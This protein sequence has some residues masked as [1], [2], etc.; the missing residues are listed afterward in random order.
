MRSFRAA[1]VFLTRI[2]VGVGR[3]GP[4]QLSR[5]VP[6]F[7]IVGAGI[8]ALVG[9]VYLALNQA[10][11]ATVSATVAVSFG[12]AITG[13]F[14][15]D[16]LADCADAFAGGTTVER[17]LEILKDSRLGTYGTSALALVLLIE[18]A[19]LAALDPNTGLRSLI[20]A[21]AIGRG[22]SV[23]VMILSRKSVREGLGADYISELNRIRCA[24]GILTVVVAV[25]LINGTQGLLL[26]VF[27]VPA[28]LLM[29]AWSYRSIGGVVGDSLGAITQLSQTSVLIGA[30]T[31]NS[32]VCACSW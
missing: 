20:S 30:V 31:L 14:H 16:G 23:C 10:L 29:W 7:P 3:N 25:F 24:L 15:I 4:P 17:R 8:G 32:G 13:A 11:P 1:I 12:V 22:A 18:M 21:Y 27:A 5:T 19:A 28:T 6:W 26:P 2:P 9:L